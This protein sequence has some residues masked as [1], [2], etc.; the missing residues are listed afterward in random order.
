M[1]FLIYLLGVVDG[2]VTTTVY[3]SVFGWLIYAVVFLSYLIYRN[4]TADYE[5]DMKRHQAIADNLLGYIKSKVIIAFLTI[6]LLFALLVP[7]SK[8]IAAIYLVP[9]I[10]E[11]KQVQQVPGKVLKLLNVKLD[12][13]IEDVVGKTKKKIKKKI[14][15]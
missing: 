13:W 1:G 3:V 10:V 8:T 4:S 7:N 15:K 9:K 14:K 2:L 12:N 11:N 6:T 5:R